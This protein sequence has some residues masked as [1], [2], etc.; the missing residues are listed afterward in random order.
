M[1]E[2]AQTYQIELNSIDAPATA[3]LVI[4]RKIKILE[5]NPILAAM[6]GYQP[7]E[8]TDTE[9]TILDLIYIEA[10]GLVLKHTL[11]KY[12]RPYEAV[13]L[14]KDGTTFAIRILDQPLAHP[15]SIIRAMVIQPIDEQKNPAQ[16]L[17]SWPQTKQALA[18]QLLKTTTQLR[19][20]NERLQ[21]ELDERAQMEADLR[22]RVR[23]QQ[24][25]ADLGQ[26]AL[27]SPNLALLMTDAVTIAAQILEAEL[28]GI[29][30]LTPAKDSLR[31]TAG[32]GWPAGLVGQTTLELTA[33]YPAG[34][35]LLTKQPLMIEN[36]SY[37]SRFSQAGWLHR[38]QVVSG[39][40]LV[41]QS[42]QEPLGVLEVYTTRRRR[43]TEDDSHFLQ[44]V[45]NILSM[46]WERAQNEDQLKTAAQQQEA[47]LREIHDRVRNNLQVILSLLNLQAT[48][49]RTSHQSKR[50]LQQ[51][52]NRIR[53]MALIH[54]KLYGAQSLAQI[55]L[56][57][58]IEALLAH[59]FR[60]Y[61]AYARDLS[62]K[63]QADELFLTMETAVPCGLII[64]ELVTNALQHAF[65]DGQGGQ[66]RV[67]C[68]Q[69]GDGRFRLTVA[70]DGL[71]LS[72]GLD[73]R[74][75]DT[76]GLQLVKTLVDQLAGDIELLPAAG[77]AFK[78]TF[79][80]Q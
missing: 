15:D 7:G 66:V 43:F 54:E 34:Y 27:A 58:Y 9:R 50:V 37:D 48:D 80:P 13:G 41:I 20:A 5:V 64:N 23:Q 24:A 46:A 55:E 65:S 68:Y 67:E 38:H 57:V 29:F 40:S 16:I 22:A 33:D 1:D 6:F 51:A 36:L 18:D 39:L 69:N 45:T 42:R 71:G 28:A 56:G 19:F 73:F 3:G 60:S 47:L 63:V 26:R 79:S 2:Q 10:R 77:T 74:E 44:A 12:E 4:H 75:A 61:Q 62:F 49:Y 17:A 8:L 35:A 21:L 78:I 59:L 52:Q 53:A 11:I 70:D 25:V 30:E 31:L 76:L 32:A 72:A 14:H